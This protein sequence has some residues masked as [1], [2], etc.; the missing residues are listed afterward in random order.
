MSTNAELR[1]LIEELNLAE[2]EHFD[3]EGPLTMRLHRAIVALCDFVGIENIWNT[4]P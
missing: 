1:G 4:E 2:K 3:D